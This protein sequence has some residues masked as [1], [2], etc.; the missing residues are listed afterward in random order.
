MERRGPVTGNREEGNVGTTQSV[1][2]GAN[3]THASRNKVMSDTTEPEAEVLKSGTGEEAVYLN[4]GVP[5]GQGIR[6]KG[7]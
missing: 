7:G 2:C 4:R 5:R 6:K 3:E 1:R